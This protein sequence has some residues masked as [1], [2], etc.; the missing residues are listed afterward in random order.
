MS[1]S[2][3]TYP[4]SIYPQQAGLGMG[5][6]TGDGGQGT[7]ARLWEPSGLA[8]ISVPD[9][10]V[11]DGYRKAL[12]IADT[13]NNKI[14]KLLLTDFIPPTP[15]P[16]KAPTMRPTRSPTSPSRK[17]SSKPTSPTRR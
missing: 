1:I 10:K 16:S 2:Y 7:S 4:S 15:M 5:G 13:S 6:F 17:P 11:P 3:V 8:L 12:Y 9:N 14:R